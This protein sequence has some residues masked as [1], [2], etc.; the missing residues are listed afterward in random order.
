MNL[1]TKRKADRD[2]VEPEFESIS[3]VSR[4]GRKQ[5]RV[6]REEVEQ[7]TMGLEWEKV[8][9]EELGVATHKAS[10]THLLGLSQEQV[11]RVLERCGLYFQVVVAPGVKSLV[12]G[13][14]DLSQEQSV[15]A[16]VKTE[17]GT[18]ILSVVGTPSK[19]GH[20]YHLTLPDNAN[21]KGTLL[22]SGL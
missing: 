13:E 14:Y 4:T 9:G 10:Q 12:A 19:Y 18:T 7:P 20:G 1:A 2:V 8:A 21:L 11:G 16:F 17:L 6:A 22:R 5:R 3:T 15:A